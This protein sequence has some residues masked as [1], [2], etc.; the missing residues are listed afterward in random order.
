MK[1]S[2]NMVASEQFFQYLL[3]N[4]ISISGKE[5]EQ[6]KVSI[7]K[8]DNEKHVA[9]LQ[10]FGFIVKKISTGK[11]EI[12]RNNITYKFNTT[13]TAKPDISFSEKK[14]FIEIKSLIS[15]LINGTTDKLNTQII[16][17]I[18]AIIAT[19]GELPK[20]AF[21][22]YMTNHGTH[23]SSLK[24][25]NIKERLIKSTGYSPLSS[26]N[27]TRRY[28]SDR[29]DEVKTFNEGLG[30]TLFGAVAIIEDSSQATLEGLVNNT[31]YKKKV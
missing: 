8:L 16:K 5:C 24:K 18:L 4:N 25:K 31:F 1:I 30:F 11:Y 6:E 20:V 13:I 26:M 21:V 19:T 7:I 15:T 29:L 22:A 14:S 28:I 3:V 12:T 23:F 2:K 10:K 9:N 27:R 17:Y